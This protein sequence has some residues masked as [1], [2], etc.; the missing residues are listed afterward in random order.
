MGRPSGCGSH[1]AE[2]LAFGERAE[3]GP[4]TEAALDHLA[5]CARCQADL[6]EILLA[7]HAV[8]RLMAD[9]AVADPPADAWERLRTRVQRPVASAWRARTSLAGVIAG[10]G[11]VAALVGPVAVF[12]SATDA[13]SEPG[14]PAAVLQA[15]TEA[16]GR[17]EAAF[18][19]RA[20]VEPTQRPVTIVEAPAAAWSGPDGLGRAVPPIK[21][22]VNPARAD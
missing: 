14:P 22:D 6:T 15:R 21:I 5:R 13:V 1:R 18:L 20:R 7:G 16:D 19:N 2:L 4:R 3:R 11:L 12:H 9:A 17:A 10:A 8:R